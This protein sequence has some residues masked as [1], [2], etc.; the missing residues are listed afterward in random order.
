[1]LVKQKD[2]STMAMGP[3]FTKAE[4]CILASGQMAKEMAE[5]HYIITKAVC[6]LAC[7]KMIKKMAV[8]IFIPLA[9]ETVVNTM[10]L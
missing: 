8:E 5:E 6:I 1:M 7:G 4:M 10:I 9:M 3:T 2:R